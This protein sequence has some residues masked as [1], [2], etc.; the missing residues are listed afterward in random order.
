[1][2]IYQGSCDYGRLIAAYFGQIFPRMFGRFCHDG[3]AI[4]DMTV[5]AECT[6]SVG[7][8]QERKQHLTNWVLTLLQA[9]G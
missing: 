2:R 3:K 8:E 9:F 5:E 6:G 1:M 7:G 4:N